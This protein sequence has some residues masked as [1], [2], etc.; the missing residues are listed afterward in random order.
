MIQPN[1]KSILAQ[2]KFGGS[3]PNLLVTPQI[4]RSVNEGQAKAAPNL[5]RLPQTP[6]PSPRLVVMTTDHG[7]IYGVSLVEGEGP[8]SVLDTA[9]PFTRGT[10]S[11]GPLT[12]REGGRGAPLDFRKLG[13]VRVATASNTTGS[14]TARGALSRS[15]NVGR[16]P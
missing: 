9:S 16:G 1:F 10:T 7:R 3:R 13:D 5:E 11:R 8:P 12:A 4:F 15:V 2:S 6:W 14:T